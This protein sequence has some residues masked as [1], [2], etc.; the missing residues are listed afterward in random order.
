V[1]E[2]FDLVRHDLLRVEREIAAQTGMAIQ[3][4]AEIGAYLQEGG[5]KRL[6]PALLMLAARKAVGRWEMRPFAWRG[7]G[8]HSQRH[9]NP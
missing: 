7:G 2:I 4:V 3:P 6:R 8:A 1:K 5:G 9:A